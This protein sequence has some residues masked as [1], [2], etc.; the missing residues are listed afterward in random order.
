M[1]NTRMAQMVAPWIGAEK[2]RIRARNKAQEEAKLHPC[3]SKFY[4]SDEFEMP[5]KPVTCRLM[6]GDLSFWCPN[7]RHMEDVWSDYSHAAKQSRQKRYL[8][9]RKLRRI[10]SKEREP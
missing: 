9:T 2:N 3:T 10:V 8:L 1:T 5:R 6:G 4:G 7:C